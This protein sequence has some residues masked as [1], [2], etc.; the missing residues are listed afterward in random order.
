M[1]FLQKQASSSEEGPRIVGDPIHVRTENSVESITRRGRRSPN[2]NVERIFDPRR[3]R[4]HLGSWIV[5]FH[6]GEVLVGFARNKDRTCA[7]S[8]AFVPI[9]VGRSE[10][11]EKD[12]NF[13]EDDIARGHA[14]IDDPRSA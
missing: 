6:G 10:E 2:R 4:K 5:G 13:E 3:V 1:D 12:G 9:V 7:F 14:R 8:R 11:I